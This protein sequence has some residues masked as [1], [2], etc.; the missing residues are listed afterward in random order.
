MFGAAL[1]GAV[2][3]LAAVVLTTAGFYVLAREAD[4]RPPWP[5]TLCEPGTSC[6]SATTLVRWSY[7]LTAIGVALTNHRIIAR[8]AALFRA[9]PQPGAS[10]ATV[11]AVAAQLSIAAFAGA[12]EV[13]DIPPEAALALGRWVGG[14]WLGAILWPALWSIALAAIGA[15]AHAIFQ[16]IPEKLRDD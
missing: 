7:L 4:L 12:I 8:T 2:M 9:L 11:R 13:L 3:Q 1:A 16:A 6:G 5:L 10:S 15:S 14:G